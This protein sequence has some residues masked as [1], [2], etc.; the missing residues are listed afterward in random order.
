MP[1]S[2]KIAAA[3]KA[4]KLRRWRAWLLRQRAKPLGIVE[5]TDERTAEAAAAGQ[6]G[7]S[8]EQRRRLVLRAED[9]E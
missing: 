6:F 7:L 1:P 4:A 2:K 9:T 3:R 5:A 8:A